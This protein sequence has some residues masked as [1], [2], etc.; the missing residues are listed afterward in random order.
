[1][2]KIAVI[3]P[4]VCIVVLLFVIGC[5]DVHEDDEPRLGGKTVKKPRAPEE[6]P[7]QDAPETGSSEEDVEEDAEDEPVMREPR[8]LPMA[9]APEPADDYSKETFTDGVTLRSPEA[10]INMWKGLDDGLNVDIYG[11]IKNGPDMQK[12]ATVTSDKDACIGECTGICTDE[13]PGCEMACDSVYI[14]ICTSAGATMA[15]CKAGCSAI[16]WPPSIAPCMD[17][18]DAA[19]NAACSQ[20]ELGEC[21]DDCNKLYYQICMNECTKDCS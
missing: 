15:V 18:C 21:K 9:E 20:E 10:S 1:M 11:F 13:I 16:P 14:H 17:Q 19:F 6:K 3:G 4:I 2:K 5:I 8:P 12:G 7:D